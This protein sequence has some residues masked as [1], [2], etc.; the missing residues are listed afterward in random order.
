MGSKSNKCESEMCDLPVKSRPDVSRFLRTSQ[1]AVRP[2][3]MGRVY[4]VVTPPLIK[5]GMAVANLNIR[6][7]G[8]NLKI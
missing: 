3:G 1:P 8:A 2:I 6:Y 7:C 4:L 5:N